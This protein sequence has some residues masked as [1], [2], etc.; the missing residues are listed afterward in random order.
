MGGDAG[1]KKKKK[2][3]KKVNYALIGGERELCQLPEDT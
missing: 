3:T 1:E 2:R